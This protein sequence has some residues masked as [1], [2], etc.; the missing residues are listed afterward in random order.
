MLVNPIEFFR[1]L[2]K[3]ICPECGENI[4]EEQAESYL[5]ECDRCLAKKEE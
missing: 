5:I 4:H 2:P 1:T 3:K